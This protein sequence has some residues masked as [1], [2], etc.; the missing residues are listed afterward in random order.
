MK[1]TIIAAAALLLS[2]CVNPQYRPNCVAQSLCVAATLRINGHTGVVITRG[3]TDDP[4]VGHR[5]TITVDPVTGKWQYWELK[6]GYVQKCDKPPWYHPTEE[7]T[8]VESARRIGRKPG[9]GEIRKAQ[10]E[11]LKQIKLFRESR[12]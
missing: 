8:I 11:L 4:N 7:L 5:H 3:D 1:K 10:A 12:R 2:G 9:S 6:H